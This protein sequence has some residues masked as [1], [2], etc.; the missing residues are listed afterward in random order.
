MSPETANRAALLLFADRLEA[1][2]QTLPRWEPGAS[3][4][5]DL[6]A[7]RQYVAETALARQLQALLGC[8]LVMSQERK[9]VRLTLLDI[10]VHSKQGIA[11]ACRLWTERVRAQLASSDLEPCPSRAAVARVA[12]SPPH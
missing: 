7:E 2:A 10:H 5:W 12:S 9:D 3:E 1:Q 6:F 11:Q 4:W 8:H